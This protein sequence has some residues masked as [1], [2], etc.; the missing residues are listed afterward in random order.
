MTTDSSIS[1][2][3]KE[4]E[5]RFELSYEIIEKKPLGEGTYGEVYKAQNH[6][7]GEI[8]AMKKMKLDQEDEG[9]PSTAIREVSLLKEL[10]HPNVVQL[11]DVFCSPKKLYLVFEFVDNDLKK[12]M[13]QLGGNLTPVQIKNFTFQLVKGVEFCHSHRILHRDLKPQ[14]LLIDKHG[15]LKIADF[16]LARAFALPIPKLTHEVV[17]VWYRA[18][19]ILLGSALYSVP[20]DIWSIGAILAEMATGSP[21]FPGDSEIDTIFKIFMKLGTPNEQT[22]PGLSSL[23]D[24]KPSFP[25]WPAKG[26]ANIR[27]TQAQLG[28]QGVNLLEMMTHYDPKKRI[29]ARRA[30]GHVY[31]IEGVD[32]A[33][34]GGPDA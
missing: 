9:V 19:E 12:Y 25:K 8:L 34:F 6:K 13:K 23:P 16:G 15:I 14:N 27:N 24:F 26:W 22:W 31:L 32:R 30:L 4:Q 5:R 11:K 1:D 3:L 33:R 18:P 21:L 7:T 2:T 20:V 17:T 10:S 29:S 28:D